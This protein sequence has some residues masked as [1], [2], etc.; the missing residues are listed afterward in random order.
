[1]SKNSLPPLDD[2]LTPRRRVDLRSIRTRGSDDEAI[3]RNSRILGGEWGAQ[4]SLD[5]PRQKTPT[6]SLRIEVPEYLDR[7]L[8]LNAAEQR[9]TK[10]YLVVDA[11][12]RAGYH[13]DEADLV[14]DR[15]KFRR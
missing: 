8:A 6:A 1:M 5:V 10:Q 4:T 13:V 7:E 12:R 11:L 3:E 15:R 2:E 14:T 9:V